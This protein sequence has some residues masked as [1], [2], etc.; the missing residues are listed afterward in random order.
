MS[1]SVQD[2]QSP[3]VGYFR[4]NGSRTAPRLFEPNSHPH[5]G[6]YRHAPAKTTSNGLQEILRDK[7]TSLKPKSVISTLQLFNAGSLPK[8]FEK[9]TLE[10]MPTSHYNSTRDHRGESNEEAPMCPICLENFTDGDEI[11]N[12]KCSHCFHKSCVDIWLLGT[13]SSEMTTT[14]CPT[15]RQDASSVISEPDTGSSV[16]SSQD[17]ATRVSSI[18]AEC[19]IRVGQFL[20][21]EGSKS[22]IKPKT[23][24]TSRHASHILSP[25]Q[26][27]TP[28]SSPALP[29][30]ASTRS[31]PL[32]PHLTISAPSTTGQRQLHNTHSTNSPTVAAFCINTGPNSNH[33][34]R[35]MSSNSSASSFS[36]NSLCTNSPSPNHHS[37]FFPALDD[38]THASGRSDS[39]FLDVNMDENEI[40]FFVLANNDEDISSS[41]MTV[42]VSEPECD[43]E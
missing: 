11:R 7:R 13:M 42:N 8:H 32:P 4:G 35:A 37:M 39:T 14:V 41:F 2:K 25:R 23:T 33:T 24:P 5:V 3:Y 16:Y 31:P 17:D 40:N 12:L 6:V 38:S 9:K 26:S 36:S 34:I 29:P 19:F 10:M 22:K 15:C 20:L 21:S 43:D 27:V 18:P 28:I 1:S 30:I